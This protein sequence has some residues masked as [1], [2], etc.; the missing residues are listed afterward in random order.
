M[1]DFN[2]NLLIYDTDE[3]ALKFLDLMYFMIS[4][5]SCRIYLH[6]TWK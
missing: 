6:K 3:S 1:V 4:F 5:Q 2:K